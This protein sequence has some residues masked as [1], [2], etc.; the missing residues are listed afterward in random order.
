MRERRQPTCAFGDTFGPILV[1]RCHLALLRPHRCIL[2]C[3]RH[4]ELP[5][6]RAPCHTMPKHAHRLSSQRRSIR[7]VRRYSLG[8]SEDMRLRIRRPGFG[9]LPARVTE[10][11]A[12]WPCEAVQRGSRVVR[13]LAGRWI[14]RRKEAASDTRLTHGSSVRRVQDLAGCVRSPHQRWPGHGTTDRHAA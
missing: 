8:C 11:P 10:N 5:A 13:P 4:R 6:D 9:S 7:S 14:K 1:F 12:R 3:V 2:V